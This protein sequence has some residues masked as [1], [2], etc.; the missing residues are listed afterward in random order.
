MT[1]KYL[2]R[3][4]TLNLQIPAN[5]TIASGAVVLLGRGT[6]VMGG[7]AATAQN[8]TTN[9]PYDSNDGYITVD[10]VG[11]FNLSVSASTQGSP[12]AGAQIRIGDAIYADGGTYDVL[13]GITYGSKLSADTTGTFIGLALAPIAAGLTATI[14]VLLKNAA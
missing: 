1:N 5:T 3:F 7:V 4:A 11:A 10:F 12:S 2:E 14:P 6:H 8:P 9:P 13:T